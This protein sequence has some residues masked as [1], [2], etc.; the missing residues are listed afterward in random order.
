MG[1]V[2]LGRSDAGR[3]VAVKVVQAEHAQ[4]PEFR[5]RFAREVAAARRVGG[6]WTADVLDADTDAAVPWVATQYVPGPDLTRVVGRDFGPLPED[7]VR[8][9]AHRLALA[10]AA[11]HG[12][13]LIH[14]DLKPSNVLV[15]VDG[16]RVIDFGIA[17]AMDTLAPQSLLTRT[18]MLIGSPGFMSPEQ[19]RGLELTAASDVFCLGAVLVYAAT[20]RLLFGAADTGLN[21][22]LFRVAEEAA[23]LT[24]VPESLRDLVGACLAKDPAERPTLQEVADRTASGSD[25]VWLPSAILA[26]LGRH[27]AQLLDFAPRAPAGP[28]PDGPAPNP[29]VRLGRL[30]PSV[31]PRD[32]YTPTAAAHPGAPPAFGPPPGTAGDP[33]R[34]APAPGRAPDP[35]RWRGLAAAVFAQF[36][37]VL[38]AASLHAA[39]PSLA[40]D[41]A[42]RTT[43]SLFT[44]YGVALGALL[45]L[46]GHLVDRVGGRRTLMT[47]LSAVAVAAVGGAFAPTAGV[48]IAALALQ[49]AGA[50]LVTPAVLALV[51]ARFTEPG[52]RGRALGVYAAVAVGGW[53]A[54]L[55]WGAV[56]TEFVSWRT[57]LFADVL[58]V[59]IAL[60]VAATRVR[61][62]AEPGR[63]GLTTPGLLLGSVGALL[64]SYGLYEARPHSWTAASLLGPLG[65]GVL[66][67]AASGVPHAAR[68]SARDRDRI[69]G[70]VV[71]CLGAAGL[72]ALFPALTLVLGPVSGLSPAAAGVA[73]LPAGIAFVIGAARI[74]PSLRRV[75]PRKLITAGLLPAAVG[76]LPLGAIGNG[77]T[78]ALVLAGSVPA[79]LGLGTAMAPLFSIAVGDAT[80]RGRGGAA[81]VAATALQL[82]T[83]LGAALFGAGAPAWGGTGT[84][85][86]FGAAGLTLV[87]GLCAAALITTAAAADPPAIARTGPRL[88]D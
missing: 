39:A 12:A 31:S 83:A 4:H 38:D 18:G 81:A 67:L 48:L 25:E 57:C 66:L 30:Q 69:V 10:L 23:D 63:G 21:A 2:Y 74:A 37:V 35:R 79:G 71:L 24:G 34:P 77:G 5:R 40:R 52:E 20:G 28:A 15:T 11:V 44:A 46:G 60:V 64:T 87:A 54:G 16:P 62:H 7:S 82:G 1:L 55:A 56:M 68:A 8:V 27:A 65:I 36:V 72:F 85:A 53:P 19:V 88:P 73:V 22:H 6:E 29:P 3:T 58:L 33:V 84:S 80:D 61:D 32:L 42:M 51:S 47:G 76:L 50:A 41:L 13:G 43:Y 70:L 14:R 26:Q 78:F 59:L 45:L 86:L 75:A 49:G 9:L 17:R